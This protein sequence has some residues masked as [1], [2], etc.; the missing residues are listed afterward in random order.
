MTTIAIIGC[1]GIPARYGGFETLA[2]NLVRHLGEQY[3]FIVYCS[4]DAYPEQPESFLGAELK[5][6]PLDANGAQSIPYDI[7]SMIDA[8]RRADV[9]LI[10]GV[11]G[12]IF[13]PLLRLFCRG[14]IIV[15]LDG[16]DWKRPKWG[17]AAR[18]F[19]KFSETVA[20]RFAD[21]LVAD[22][23]AIHDY[24][25]EYYGKESQL[26]EYG[27]D[28][29]R[30]DAP[31]ARAE[32]SSVVPMH[33]PDTGKELMKTGFDEYAI[34]VCRIEPEN[35]VHIILQA[36]AEAQTLPLV[37]LGNWNYSDYGRRLRVQYEGHANLLLLDP[38][39]EQRQLYAL[40]SNA[41]LY[42]HG[43]SSG[44]TNPSLV[45][46]MS[47]GLP[48]IAFDVVFNRAT[49][50]N[51]AAYFNDAATLKAALKDLLALDLAANAT[52]MG[53]L[54]RRR[55]SWAIIASKYTELFGLAM[56]RERRRRKPPAKADASDTQ[57]TTTAA[58]ETSAEA[59]SAQLP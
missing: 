11:S 35:N 32:H 12:C 4:R 58:A 8:S 13:L 10:L 29:A 14:K 22:N 33:K 1:K 9:L 25:L 28:N 3:D 57:A 45:E 47:L 49:T 55:Y 31:E 51:Q 27:G 36:F 53:E 56:G 21:Y 7:W 30:A 23:E 20:A 6:L 50:E 48:V 59:K 37:F 38:I 52:R 5:Y 43:H 19:L 40:R 41:A 24:I 42:I 16:M 34:A 2:E 46:S 17:R 39:F 44:G 18:A 26:V 15:N 54:A